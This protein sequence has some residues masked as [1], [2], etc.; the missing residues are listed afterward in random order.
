MDCVIYQ[1]FRLFLMKHLEATNPWLGIAKSSE[2]QGLRYRSFELVRTLWV[3]SDRE[4][5]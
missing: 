4:L 5:T 1:Y 3:T 2:S